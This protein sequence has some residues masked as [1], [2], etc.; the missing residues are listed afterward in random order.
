MSLSASVA[1]I[2]TTAVS[3]ALFSGTDAVVAWLVNAGAL[4]FV[5]PLPVLDQLLSPSAFFALT[6]T[7]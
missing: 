2:V 7:S 1:A 6:C 4:L 5:L 3:S